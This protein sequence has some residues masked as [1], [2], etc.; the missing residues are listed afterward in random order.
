MTV[1]LSPKLWVALTL[2]FVQLS[3]VASVVGDR[4]IVR[5]Q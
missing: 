1:H 3:L 5:H 2:N 4:L